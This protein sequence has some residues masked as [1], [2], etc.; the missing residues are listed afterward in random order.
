MRKRQQL[1][2]N[3]IGGRTLL[4]IPVS[5]PPLRSPPALFHGHEGHDGDVCRPFVS[6]FD[7]DPVVSSAELLT[8]LW[9]TGGFRFLIS[10]LRPYRYAP[11]IP[12]YFRQR[13]CVAAAF[14]GSSSQAAFLSARS[15]ALALAF[16]LYPAR[17]VPCASLALGVLPL[18]RRLSSSLSLSSLHRAGSVKRERSTTTNRLIFR[19]SAFV[20]HDGDG[21]QWRRPQ[22]EHKPAF[23]GH[24]PSRMQRVR[25]LDP[26]PPRPFGVHARTCCLTPN[27]KGFRLRRTMQHGE[28]VCG[29][30]A[31]MTCL[32]CFPASNTA[33]LWIANALMPLLT[34]FSYPATDSVEPQLYA[35]LKAGPGA[36]H[37][38]ANGADIGL[39]KI[40]YGS[41][42][43]MAALWKHTEEETT[44]S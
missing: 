36:T 30:R 41:P 22:L 10:C 19:D 14:C 39:K 6:G 24:A 5:I 26:R 15:F 21:D 20:P 35:M 8:L 27:L 33:S 4:A 43:A 34:S 3:R 2:F 7:N 23:T 38:D 25:G 1:L 12:S 44:V 17:P 42:E 16:L 29:G 28:G 9:Q 11:S 37:T 32:V 13:A 18:L 40:Y 31:W